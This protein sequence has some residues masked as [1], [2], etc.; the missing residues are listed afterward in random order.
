MLPGI[1]YDVILELAQ[2]H[3]QPVKIAEI[4]KLNFVPPTRSG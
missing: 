2:R 4:K 3:G 1:T